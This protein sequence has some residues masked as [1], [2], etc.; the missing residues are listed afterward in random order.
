MTKQ[1]KAAL[2]EYAEAIKA[3]GHAAGEPIIVKYE[4]QYADF[5]RWAN[6]VALMLRADELLG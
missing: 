5:R 4:E 6:A 1:M 3:N 2:T